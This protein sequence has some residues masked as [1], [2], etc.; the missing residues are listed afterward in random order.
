MTDWILKEAKALQEEL[1]ANRRWLHQHP[2]LGLHLPETT[3][4]VKSKL[5]EMGVSY[6]EICDSGLVVLLGKKPGKCILLR[7]DMDALPMPD[8]SGLPFASQNAGVAH[9]CGHD[10]HTAMMLGVIK[11]LKAH[12]DEL[13]GTVKI[14]FQ[15]AEE[16]FAGAEV[17]VNAGLLEN[18][19]VDAAVALHVQPLAPV[20]SGTILVS[21]PGPTLASCDSFRITVTGKGSH[22]AWPE[23][24]VDPIVTT[25]RIL[26]GL[27]NIQTRELKGTDVAVL[28]CGTI[29]AGT[30]PNI[31]PSSVTVEG[32]LRT[33]DEEVRQFC[34]QR[35]KEIVSSV[36]AAFRAEGVFEVLGG[37]SP[38]CVDPDLQKNVYG[39]LKDLL[40]DGA[41]EKT[42]GPAMGAD[43]FSNVTRLCPGMQIVLSVGSKAEGAVYPPHNPKAYFNED[44]M[45]IGT[46]AMAC[47]GLR[48]LQEHS[49]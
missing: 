47:I 3:A 37:C 36:A 45:Y 13:N 43:D 25:A 2:E 46:A 48:W 35:A 34:L 15:P 27:Q 10:L 38:L 18:P 32:T 6:Q 5:D 14:M 24:G 42:G 1:V 21:R 44:P 23:Q 31:I 22:G 29:H 20:P 49:L 41:Q 39:Y 40:G 26:T 16:T 11:L 19:K 12:E 33:L 17:M 7:A 4:F 30:A 8:E 9:T 28:T